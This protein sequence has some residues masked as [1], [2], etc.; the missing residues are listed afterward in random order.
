MN[1][2]K[3]III[4][5]WINN[6]TFNTYENYV[7]EDDNLETAIIKLAKNI[8]NT[9]K[10]YAWKADKSILFNFKSINWDGY[11]PNP[12]KATN[13]KSKQINEAVIY[14]YNNGLFDYSSINIIFEK[15]FPELKNNPYYFPDKSYQSLNQLKVKE[16]ILKNLETINTSPIIDTSLN[17]HKYE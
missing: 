2:Y 15:D 6:K 3:K 10:F 16:Q 1:L 11:S 7:Y 17:I 9:D 13:L 4:I 14:Q 5:N 12:L 8:Y